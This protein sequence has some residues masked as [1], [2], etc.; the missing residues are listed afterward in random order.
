MQLTVTDP[1]DYILEDRPPHSVGAAV[2]LYETLSAW[3][4]SP[5]HAFQVWV[6][7][8]DYRDARQKVYNASTQK[9]Y[10][11]MWCHL[12]AWLKGENIPFP[13]LTYAHLVDFL[14]KN[15]LYKEHRGRYVRIV[16]RAFDHMASLGFSGPNPGR[17]T[18]KEGHQGRLND[19]PRFLTA[20]ERQVVI[21]RLEAGL[22]K[23]REAKTSKECWLEARDIAMVGAMIGAGLK[24]A[25]TQGVT[26]NC[27]LS[28]GDAADAYVIEI[29]PRRGVM[30]RHQARVLPFAAPILRRWRDL[31]NSHEGEGGLLF[32]ADR[33]RGGPRPEKAGAALHA[34]SVFRR[35]R[36]FLHAC[37]VTGERASA[38]TL[39]NTYAALLIDE[40]ATNADL[41]DHLGLAKGDS[42]ERLR[43]NYKH[44]CDGRQTPT[45]Q[46]ERMTAHDPSMQRR[47]LT[48]KHPE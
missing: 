42:V 8:L 17:K 20:Q 44:W 33:E 7:R 31:R 10:N 22:E 37:G 38:Q 28:G 43:L 40:G 13:E 9:V 12:L 26:V 16:E 25:Q 14:D 19:D 30:K 15:S 21:A 18:A 6:A 5:D 35:T 27:M 24:V 41:A 34:V 23:I 2:D 48:L 11:A 4:D 45:K 36:S 1:M 29:P 32:P 46:L 39:R 47:K 3:L